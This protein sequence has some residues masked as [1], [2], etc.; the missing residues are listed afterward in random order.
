MKFFNILWIVLFSSFWVI[1]QNEQPAKSTDVATNTAQTGFL[2]T[3]DYG[4]NFRTRYENKINYSARSTQQD[5]VLTRIRA[6]LA[7]PIFANLKAFVQLQ[8]A[9][10]M[11]NEKNEAPVVNAESNPNLYKDPFD[12]HQLYIDYSTEFRSIPIKLRFGRQQIVL[13]GKRL[14][15]GL[16][17]INTDRVKDG[18]FLHFG[19]NKMPNVRLFSTRLVAS[20]PNGINDY[21]LTA[22]RYFNSNLHGIY[23]SDKSMFGV[24]SWDVYALS[25][26]QA[27]AKDRVNTFGVR[28]VS[29]FNRI[30]SEF[31]TAFQNGKFAGLDHRGQMLHIDVNYE[32]F[33]YRKINIGVAYNWASG[34]KDP[35]DQQH[36]TFDNLYPL[37]H[38]FYGYMDLFGLQN[39]KNL[40][41]NLSA[42]IG[43][44]FKMRFA[45]HEFWLN[46]PG[47][48]SWYHAGLGVL[49]SA[50]PGNNAGHAGREM[51]I[52]LNYK[53]PGYKVGLESGI[54]MFFWGNYFDQIQST[55]NA[56][57]FY[58][59]MNYSL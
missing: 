2:N 35:E 36:Q 21:S 10:V 1:A 45:W 32:L 54:S 31:E 28:V 27:S 20:D 17:W 41:F 19:N 52:K 22:N 44:Q 25:R 26:R 48:D 57:F 47:S 30:R 9:R 58:L 6:Y 59:M 24:M 3:F 23:F 40:E 15:S 16:G 38:A 50:T 42:P 11:G 49:R 8:D 43:K 37:N 14:V 7:Y 56:G 5:Y 13:G 39:M 53:L 46:E 18:L 29:K 12:I 34:D 33:P 51:D 55:T 4:V